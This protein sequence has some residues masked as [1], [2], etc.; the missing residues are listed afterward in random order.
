MDIYVGC[1]VS[2]AATT[3][4]KLH[5]N[6]KINWN[7]KYTNVNQWFVFLVFSEYNNILII[8]QSI[9]FPFPLL[10]H[11]QSLCTPTQ[12]EQTEMVGGHVDVGSE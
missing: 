3:T 1:Y 6:P 7:W 10:S 2:Y 8:L 9:S 4:E 11:N 5:F 12:W